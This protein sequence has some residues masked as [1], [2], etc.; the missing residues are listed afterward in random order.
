MCVHLYGCLWE[1]CER[2]F[3]RPC[4]FV[5]AQHGFWKACYP[6][7]ESVCLLDEDEG[8]DPTVLQGPEGEE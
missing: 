7:S 2:W 4:A 5:Q 3:V 8:S 1:G 6:D